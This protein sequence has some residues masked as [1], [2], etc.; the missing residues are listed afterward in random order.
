MTSKPDRLIA[1][2]QAQGLTVRRSYVAGMN[3][4]DFEHT[5][6]NADELCGLYVKN[7]AGKMAYVVYRTDG[8]LSEVLVMAN[9]R[10]LETN[11]MDAFVCA[12]GDEEDED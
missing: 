12:F 11:I 1:E 4:G 5:Q 2:M 6:T 10:L 3:D 9:D 8:P 7:A